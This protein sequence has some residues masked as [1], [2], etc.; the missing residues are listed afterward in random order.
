MSAAGAASMVLGYTA[1]ELA[2][3]LIIELMVELLAGQ[4]ME[5]GIDADNDVY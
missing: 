4:I 3:K 1:C 2:V 5:Q